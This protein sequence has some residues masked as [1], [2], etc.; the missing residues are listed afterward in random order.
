MTKED[1]SEFYIL[2]TSSQ[3]DLP[4]Q[5]HKQLMTIPKRE[6]KRL[7]WIWVVLLVLFTSAVCW[8]VYNYSTYIIIRVLKVVRFVIDVVFLEVPPLLLAASSIGVMILIAITVYLI[9]KLEM[10]RYMMC[11][12]PPK[13]S[14]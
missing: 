13:S 1:L 4:P 9:M 3:P 6:A 10:D 11:W 5:L 2:L 14:V 8:L 7:Y 12:N